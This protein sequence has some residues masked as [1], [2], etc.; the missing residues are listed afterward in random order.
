VL[1]I[2]GEEY[3]AAGMQFAAADSRFLANILLISL[4]FLQL[5]VLMC[6]V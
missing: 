6:N 2:F 4:F 5:A 3:K 1:L